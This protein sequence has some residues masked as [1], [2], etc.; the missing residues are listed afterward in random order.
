MPRSRQNSLYG[1]FNFVTTEIIAIVPLTTVE[2][3][4]RRPSGPIASEPP[5]RFAIRIASEIVKE[6]QGALNAKTGAAKENPT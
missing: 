4:K 5:K 2:G 1:G 6:G 3:R